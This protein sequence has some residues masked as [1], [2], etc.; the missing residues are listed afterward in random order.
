MISQIFS[1]FDS[2]TGAYLKPFHEATIPSCIRSFTDA[3]KD[4]ESTFSKYPEDFTLFHLG[5]FDDQNAE[6]TML[7]AHVPLGKAIDFITPSED[8]QLNLVSGE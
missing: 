8:P 3:C 2:K 5:H 6:F 7:Q 1:V 4:P